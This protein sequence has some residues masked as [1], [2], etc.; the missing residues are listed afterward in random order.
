MFLR[1]TVNFIGRNIYRCTGA[2]SSLACDEC[3]KDH[4]SCSI[5][6]CLQKCAIML[7]V[8]AVGTGK[9]GGDHTL[10]MQIEGHRACAG[11]TETPCLERQLL[12][13]I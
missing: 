5:C 1:T 2:K 8:S 9:L 6:I 13:R 10:V 11:G 7:Q 4:L 3:F 12:A